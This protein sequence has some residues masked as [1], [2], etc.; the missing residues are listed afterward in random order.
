MTRRCKAQLAVHICC[1]K[2]PLSPP[3]RCSNKNRRPQL[4]RSVPLLSSDTYALSSARCALST[5][6]R[7]G[8]RRLYYYVTEGAEDVKPRTLWKVRREDVRSD[9]DAPRV[10]AMLPIELDIIIVGYGKF[11]ARRSVLS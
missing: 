1:S 11:H 7:N 5:R 4:I 9:P 8:R 10:T 3:L 6:I 2:F